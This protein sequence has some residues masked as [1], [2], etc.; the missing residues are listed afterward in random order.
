MHSSNIAKTYKWFGTFI[1]K[2]GRYTFFFYDWKYPRCWRKNKFTPFLSNHVKRSKS[3]VLHVLLSASNTTVEFIISGEVMVNPVF[4]FC[5]LHLYVSSRMRY[6]TI[7]SKVL[8]EKLRL[9]RWHLHA[10]HGDFREHSFSD[11]NL[12]LMYFCLL[13]FSFEWCWSRSI[14]QYISNKTQRYTVYLYRVSHS[15]PK[16]AFL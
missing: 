7:Y 9:F 4:P 1:I 6:R 2:D 16:P 3:I 12:W 13:Y 10:R 11:W 5:Y 8:V 14:F 15:L